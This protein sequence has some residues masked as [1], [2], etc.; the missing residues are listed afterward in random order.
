MR[1]RVN[2][3]F[4]PGITAHPS[5]SEVLAFHE[6]IPGYAPTPLHD[7]PALAAGLG[8]GGILVKDESR[9]FGL[10]SFK[11]L[12]ASWALHRI[13]SRRKGPMTVATA[14]AGNHGCAL[15]W[16]AR[17]LGVPAVIFIPARAAPARIE[18]IR[19]QGARV[20]MVP[21]SYEDAVRRCAEQSAREGWQVVADT[22]YE[23]YLEVPHWIA[24]GYS[25]LFQEAEEQ[26]RS[27]DLPAPQAVFIQAG[28]GGLL[29]AAVDHFR[30][31]ETQPVIVAVEPVEADAL[32]ASI[33]SPDGQPASSKGRLDSIM[34]GLNC[35]RVSLTAW[36]VIRHGVELFVTVEDRLAVAAMRRLNR[37]LGAD[38]VIEAGPS[39]AAGLAGVLAVL[40]AAELAEARRFL[41]LG[42]D[43]RIMV[44]NTEGAGAPPR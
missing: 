25:T 41:H 30:A 21:G 6:S 27:R 1:A 31:L 15:A 18:S 32:F 7:C 13:R 8:L 20:E 34:A 10:Q 29:H 3:W 23:G 35:E 11:A 9:R 14:T 40:E 36:P 39:G 4:E 16:A 37:P 38:P 28:V 5:R 43:T 44:V 33:D 12:G 22:G 24:E 42:P 26:R 17:L 2:P 19:V